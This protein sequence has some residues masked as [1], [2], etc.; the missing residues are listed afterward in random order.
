MH[1]SFA[2]LT[3]EEQKIAN[4]FLNDVQRGDVIPEGGKTFKQYISEY[5][6]EAK[7]SQITTIVDVFGKDNDADKTAFHAKLDKMMNT[8]ITASTINKFGHFDL[9]KSYIDKSKAKTYLEKRGR[10]VLSSFKVNMEVDTLLGKF[11]LS[12]G[13]DV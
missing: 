6:S 11:I 7:Q 5:Q 4:H 1:K 9:L 10:V 3:Q 13:V 8:K 12:G 2:T